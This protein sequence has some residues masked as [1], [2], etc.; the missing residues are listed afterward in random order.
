M[1][2][3]VQRRFEIVGIEVKEYEVIHNVL[4]NSEHVN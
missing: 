4:G 2:E 1:F 3:L